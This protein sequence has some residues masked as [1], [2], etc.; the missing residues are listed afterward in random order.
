MPSAVQLSR[1]PLVGVPRT[2]VTS[3][4]VLAKTFAPLPVSSVKAAAK[5]AD[6]NEP[7]EVALPVEVT[8]PVRLAFVVTLPA[9]RP[10]AV[11]VMFVPTRVEGVP[12]L[13]VTRM[14]LLAKTF[15][16]LPVSSVKAPAK[17]EDVNEPREVTVP[18]EVT[19]PV[20]FD[21]AG[22]AW[23]VGSAPGPLL[24][25]TCVAVPGPADAWKAPVPVVPANTTPY[26]VAD[27]RP[28]PPCA[29]E[30]VAA[31][32][33]S[34]PV[35]PSNAT[36]ALSVAEA[37]P[38]TSPVRDELTVWFGHVPVTVMPVPWTRE[39]L[40]TPVPPLVTGS[41]VLRV[42]ELKCVTASTTFT[43][44]TNRCA[45]LPLGTV[46]PVPAA[47]FTVMLW[48]PDVLFWTR[49]CF[50]IVG[51]TISR[52]AVKLPTDVTFR[53]KAR[54]T[55]KAG[56]SRSVSVR[57]NVASV[58]NTGLLRPVMACSMAV[59]MLVLVVLPQVFDCSPLPISS[60]FR[61]EKVLAMAYSI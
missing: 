33:I 24:V 12:R 36:K 55:C 41:A 45:F 6:V 40:V 9:V 1:L 37:G 53:T 16:P 8:A 11:P 30:T 52:V 25:K 17:S 34:L 20:K 44:S 56:P 51:T 49:Y 58:A 13:G 22:S 15:A 60:N 38:T 35:V 18:T 54:G 27:V 39:G 31:C 28:V 7:K 57:V 47:V 4:G 61:S 42:N 23:N 3:V 46:M 14:G 48:P 2:G 32:L 21:V 43:P 10:E 50:S 19:A 5:L 29:T 26:A 59:P